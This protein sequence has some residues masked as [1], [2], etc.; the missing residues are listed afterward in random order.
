MSLEESQ[1]LHD[2]LQARKNNFSGS[3]DP[4]QLQHD[5]NE[6]LNSKEKLINGARIA[7]A[8]DD[9]GIDEQEYVKLMQMSRGSGT[10]AEEARIERLMGTP[11]GP[12][13]KALAKA[14]AD[15]ERPFLES[16]IPEVI[17]G[18]SVY[19]NR[20]VSVG[21][22][23]DSLQLAGKTESFNTNDEAQSADASKAMQRKIDKY[24]MLRSTREVEAAGKNE[25]GTPTPLHQKSATFWPGCRFRI[26]PAG[27]NDEDI[28]YSS[29]PGPGGRTNVR[30]VDED[31][32]Q[33][34]ESA[35]DRAGIQR[36]LRDEKGAVIRTPDGQPVEYVDTGSGVS[37]YLRD[38]V[39][40]DKLTDQYGQKI[41]IPGVENQVIGYAPQRVAQANSV[42]DQIA[43][44][45][46]QAAR[47]VQI[48]NFLGRPT[49][50]AP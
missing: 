11:K 14:R 15:V 50:S 21:D 10:P 29:I 46:A 38:R 48:D 27:A 45:R 1:R 28:I 34:D 22:P 23:R 39:T 44:D 3:N 40:G 8:L 18:T 6:Q 32:I 16:Q 41:L 20:N 31:G 36:F 25:K 17:G 47:A 33:L 49:L 35:I 42:I 9:L 12:Q 2:G 37:R 43:A 7:A 13:R 24:R 30:P 4:H 26:D 19:D 5:A